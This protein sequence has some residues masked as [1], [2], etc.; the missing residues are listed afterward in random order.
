MQKKPLTAKEND[1]NMEEKNKALLRK[2]HLI[3]N[4]EVS[5]KLIC[6]NYIGI[7]PALRSFQIATTIMSKHPKFFS[8]YFQ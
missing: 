2:L 3:I 1:P 5:N 7:M 6:T 8:K 4:T